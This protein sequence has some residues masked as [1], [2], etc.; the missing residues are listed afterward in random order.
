MESGLQLQRQ[1]SNDLTRPL[2]PP[3]H[4]RN[5]T[6][7]VPCSTGVIQEKE[8]I[9]AGTDE[10]EQPLPSMHKHTKSYNYW[11]IQSKQILCP[12]APE[13]EQTGRI[14]AGIQVLSNQ[15]WT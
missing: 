8:Q 12:L 6:G 3:A 1:P 5:N 4:E 11:L 15:N 2:T 7:Q 10:Q 13:R 9:P 14:S